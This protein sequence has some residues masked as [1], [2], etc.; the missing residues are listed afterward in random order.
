MNIYIVISTDYDSAYNH[1]V[2]TDFQTAN[3]LKTTKEATDLEARDW[4][5]ETWKLN[6]T[7]GFPIT[8]T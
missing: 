7:T 6:A 1:G 5:I 8:T 3:E 4:A 2:F